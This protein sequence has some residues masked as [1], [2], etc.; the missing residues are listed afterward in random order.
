MS[1]SLVY[2]R[3]SENTFFDS[4]Q[5]IAKD[6]ENGS[7]LKISKKI[8]DVFFG[9]S[10]LAPKS[11]EALFSSDI[12]GEPGGT[13]TD[14]RNITYITISRQTYRDTPHSANVGI[15]DGMPVVGI[16]E[17]I[18]VIG[19]AIAA[20]KALYHLFGMLNSYSK[21]RSA[22]KELKSAD[23]NNHTAYFPKTTRVFKQAVAYTAHQNHLV[24]SLLG[25]VPL[26]KPIVRLAQGIIYN[27]QKD[28]V[29]N[30]WPFARS[31]YI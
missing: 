17:G 11:F 12:P 10:A 8:N 7:P 19:S 4:C 3:Q 15:A 28:G 29:R 1:F 25:L 21:L 30:L 5:A 18:P 6:V 31:P 2:G 27:H 24:A 26:V 22:V 13:F 14:Q 23:K 9:G 16:L 20:V